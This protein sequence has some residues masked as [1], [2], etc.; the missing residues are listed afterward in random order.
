[1]IMHDA[2]IFE[3]HRTRIKKHNPLHIGTPSN[4]KQFFADNDSENVQMMVPI[5]AGDINGKLMHALDRL[6]KTL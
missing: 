3:L 1:M 6:E 2:L 5:T 4:Q